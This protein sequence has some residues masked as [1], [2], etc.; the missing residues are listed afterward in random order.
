MSRPRILVTEKLG[1][2]GLEFLSQH[3]EVDAHDL[4]PPEELPA[5]MDQ[6]DAVIIRSAHRLTRELL[7]G[8]SRLKVVARAGA[9][10]DNVDL[11]AATEFGIAVINAPGANAIAAAEHTFGLMLAVIRN[12]VW[13]DAH[14]RAGGWDRAAFLGQELYEKRLG[15]IGLGRVGRQVSRI[16]HGFRME[17]SA[18][19]PFLSAD[20]FEAHDVRQVARLEDLVAESDIL[21][22][23]TPKSGPHLDEAMLQRLPKG[24][25]VMN[26][27][28][29]GLIDEDALARL[30]DLGHI[31]GAAIDVFSHEPPNLGWPLMRSKRVVTT[32]HLGGSTHEAM[33]EVGMMTARGVL[34]ALSDQT[35]PNLVNVPIPDLPEQNLK[36]LDRAIRILGAIFSRLNPQVTSPLVLTLGRSMT[37]SVRPWL[38]QAALAAFLQDR[39]DERV[40]TVNALLIAQRQ[41]ITLLVQADHRADDDPRISLRLEGRN[42]TEVEVSVNESGV[43]V[44]K[45]AGI[46]V[47]IPWP[48]RALV[49]RHHDA[50]GVV[51]RVGTLVGQYGINIGQLHLGRRGPQGDALMI[52]TLDADPPQQLLEALVCLPDI[53]EVHVFSNLS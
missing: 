2:K 36:R 25:I 48:E 46:P 45:M 33:V 7:Q 17:V 13:G 37:T 35:P 23:H 12:I 32:P 31:A 4:L 6:Y 21:T 16:A 1:P 49:T 47:N 20:I 27:A 19:D 40:N 53:Q 18:Y 28:R 30:L 26:V 22:I 10:V 5:L 44:K 42:E 24:A 3:A 38:R 9:G 39:V 14:V 41:G 15:I 43:V 50:P 8:H 51:G 29:G 52:L 34:D 11:D